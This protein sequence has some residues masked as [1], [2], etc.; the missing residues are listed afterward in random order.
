[1]YTLRLLSSRSVESSN[2][3]PTVS[4]MARRR[5]HRLWRNNGL[6]IVNGLGIMIPQKEDRTL[7]K[8]GKELQ[9]WDEGHYA[10]VKKIK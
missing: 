1:V 6:L 5:R 10:A 9:Q 7:K 2:S 4:A 3:I 8:R